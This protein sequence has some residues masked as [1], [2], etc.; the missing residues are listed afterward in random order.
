MLFVDASVFKA[1]DGLTNLQTSG[2]TTGV[3]ATASLGIPL[4]QKLSIHGGAEYQQYTGVY[5]FQRQR[6][7]VTLRYNDPKLWT[8]FR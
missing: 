5:G 6:F 7:F 8:I 2:Q 4:N 3:S 1:N